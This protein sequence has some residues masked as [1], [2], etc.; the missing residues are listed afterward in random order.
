M[1][2]ADLF[3]SKKGHIRE[4]SKH[5]KWTTVVCVC[6]CF[7]VCVCVLQRQ[8][9]CSGRPR[10]TLWSS[11]RNLRSASEEMTWGCGT[12]LSSDAFL[13]MEVHLWRVRWPW[14]QVTKYRP[15]ERTMV[16]TLHI[17]WVQLTENESA[18]WLQPVSDWHVCIFRCWQQQNL[19]SAMLV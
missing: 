1:M 18:S 19:R 11:W 15:G 5:K 2:H 4:I 13:S 3:S 14:C 16:R 7:C 12:A 6:V 8:G 9:P 10:W 17:L